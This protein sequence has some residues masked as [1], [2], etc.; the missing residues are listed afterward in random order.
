MPFFVFVI[1]SGLLHLCTVIERK[2]RRLIKIATE[3]GAQKI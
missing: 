3:S 2:G 1:A